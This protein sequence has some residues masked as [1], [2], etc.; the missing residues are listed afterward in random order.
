[1]VPRVQ[2]ISGFHVV[3]DFVQRQERV[4]RLKTYYENSG[5]GSVLALFGCFF[6]RGFRHRVAFEHIEFVRF[7]FVL[8]QR[9]V[10]AFHL[11]FVGAFD[12]PHKLLVRARQ[13]D[14]AIVLERHDSVFPQT[15]YL[16]GSGGSDGN[17]HKVSSAGGHVYEAV[18]RILKQYIRSTIIII[19]FE[20][21]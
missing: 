4:A 6:Q 11:N 7:V 15:N 9:P 2:R 8:D 3:T 20:C 16:R 21:K 14:V 5:V 1:M 13:L 19:I 12:W 10:Q 18:G 17:G